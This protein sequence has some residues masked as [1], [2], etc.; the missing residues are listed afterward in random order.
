MESEDIKNDPSP[1]EFVLLFE[2]QKSFVPASEILRH[3]NHCSLGRS[4]ERWTFLENSP[5]LHKGIT[6]SL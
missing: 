3:T 5:P 6:K 4:R 2:Y 1:Q